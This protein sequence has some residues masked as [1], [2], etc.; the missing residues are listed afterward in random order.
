M[1]I[2]SQVA[3]DSNVKGV[4]F[5]ASAR[6]DVIASR[7]AVQVKSDKWAGERGRRK[8]KREEKERGEGGEGERGRGKGEERGK[9][10]RGKKK[11][12]EEGE[13]MEE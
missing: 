12:G 6:A 2:R 11:K 3:G 8:R 10:G 5:P 1:R 4:V 7:I 9:E 13:R